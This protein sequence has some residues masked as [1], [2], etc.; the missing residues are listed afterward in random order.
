[1][2]S[3]MVFAFQKVKSRMGIRALLAHNL[4]IDKPKNADM[5]REKLNMYHKELGRDIGQTMLAYQKNLKG[6]KPRKNAVWAHE[7]VISASP[8]KMETMNRKE[9]MAYFEESARFIRAKY[10]K[11]SLIIPSVHF[12][13]KTPH[14]HVIVQPMYNGKLNGKHFTGGS[15][16]AMAALRKKFHKD[17]A[18]KY[19]LDYGVPR[20]P[21][22]K[23]SQD[24]LRNYYDLV[25]KE[26]PL[27]QRELTSTKLELLST[28]TE[29]DEA[30]QKLGE[31]N[32]QVMSLE[33]EKNALSGSASDLRNEIDELNTLSNNARHMTRKA[34]TD[35][36][37][38]LDRDEAYRPAMKM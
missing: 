13:E 24:D 27:K 4:R 25:N 5:E 15:K 14:M 33:G 2:K 16:H 23:P 11:E 12:D 38:K 36:I 1:M 17:V 30:N 21:D 28:Q 37:D 22:N 34:L 7:Y 29:V 35:A 20:S 31:V 6:H 18:E 9:Q 26:L 3:K 19:G 10:G 32:R 8:E